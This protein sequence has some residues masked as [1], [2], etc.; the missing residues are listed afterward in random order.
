MSG[1]LNMWGPLV[2]DATLP[3]TSAHHCIA[4]MLRRGRHPQPSNSAAT[5]VTCLRPASTLRPNARCGSNA[6]SIGARRSSGTT[7]A[8]A[9]RSPSCR[10]R[11]GPWLGGLGAPHKS[12]FMQVEE[13]F[14]E[15][16]KHYESY[17]MSF[18]DDNGEVGG[19]AH[20]H[21]RS[22]PTHLSDHRYLERKRLG[23]CDPVFP[24]RDHQHARVVQ[25]VRRLDLLGHPLCAPA[26]RRRDRRRRGVRGSALG[27][28]KNGLVLLAGQPWTHRLVYHERVDA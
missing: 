20:V 17:S 28:V 21:S 7:P 25:H 26:G 8:R 16:K 6:P 10:K 3:L 15:L 1:K 14:P 9:A 24:D 11:S 13:A 2:A 22:G 19:S 5:T 12:T 4:R 18:K 23:R 27:Y